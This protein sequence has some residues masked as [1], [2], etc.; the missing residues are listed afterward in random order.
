MITANGLGDEVTEPIRFSV[1]ETG[2]ASNVPRVE[3]DRFLTGAGC[4][5]DDVAAPAAAWAALVRSPHAHADIVALDSADAEAN[6]GVLGVFT[7]K[8][9]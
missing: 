4:Y 5:S 6:P 3:D 2:I 8:G 7:I 1:T 9:T